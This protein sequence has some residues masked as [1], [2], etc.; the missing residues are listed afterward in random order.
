[1]I[2]LDQPRAAQFPGRPDDDLGGIAGPCN[3]IANGTL[4][5]WAHVDTCLNLICLVTSS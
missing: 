1:M 3:L 4:D 2:L 5:T